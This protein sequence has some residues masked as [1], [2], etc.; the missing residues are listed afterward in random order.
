MKTMKHKIGVIGSAEGNINEKLL[1]KAR[2][3]GREIARYDCYLLT[4][5]TTGLSYEAVKGA[6]EVGGFTVGFSPAQ[7][8]S[9]HVEKYNFPL[10][11]FDFIVFTGFG[12]KGRIIPF[13]R[14]S[15]AVIGISG[16]RG[17]LTEYTTAL[18]EG[19]VTGILTES[20]GVSDMI[21][22]IEEAVGKKGGKKIY[23]SNPKNLVKEV[24]ENLNL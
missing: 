2:D 22:K 8:Q 16:R 23:N 11:G 21:E 3:V 14:T 13:I 5:A 19:K 18:D 9:E 7:N 15:D 6:K 1:A 24:V 20:G 4:G 17:T 12:H 10:E